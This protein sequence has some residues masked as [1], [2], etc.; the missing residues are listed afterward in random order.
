[1][2]SRMK[3]LSSTASGQIA[4]DWVE[5][6]P[7]TLAAL[8]AECISQLGALPTERTVALIS[9]GRSKKATKAAAAELYTSR[10]F[11]LSKQFASRLGLTC[12]IVSAKHG[13]LA[14]TEAIA[15]YDVNL[16]SFRAD[17]GSS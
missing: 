9:C 3:L 10:R 17:P 16:E 4:F 7:R 12:F 8:A 13:L 1:M 14:P 11:Q 5:P 2:G 6:D 15:P